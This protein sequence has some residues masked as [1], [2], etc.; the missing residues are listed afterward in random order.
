MTI[1]Q[2]QIQPIFYENCLKLLRLEYMPL[3]QIMDLIL[4]IDTQAIL[5]A[6]TLLI[7]DCMILI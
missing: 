1:I 3:R 4:Q 6:E 7:R 5:K 2:I